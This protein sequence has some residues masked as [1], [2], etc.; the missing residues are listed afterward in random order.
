MKNVFITSLNLYFKPD[1]AGVLF[2]FPPIPIWKS[3]RARVLRVEVRALSV[4]IGAHSSSGDAHQLGCHASF[5]LV[6]P[7]PHVG[8]VAMILL[9]CTTQ[10]S[11]FRVFAMSTPPATI[12]RLLLQDLSD[13]ISTSRH[14]NGKTKQYL[15]AKTY[16]C[17]VSA[18]IS[19][20]FLGVWEF[21]KKS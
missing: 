14:W 9:V 16:F 4:S 1:P 5:G 12:Q 18:Q 13:L 19:S 8:W 17:Y 3:Y 10:P 20:L 7:V 2:G 21:R 6:A 15:F 11:P